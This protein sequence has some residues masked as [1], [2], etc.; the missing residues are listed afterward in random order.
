MPLPW[1]RRA[2][3]I[4]IVTRGPREQAEPFL[5]VLRRTY[6]PNKVL[7]V[8]S[9]G[10]NLKAQ[11]RVI[12]LLE[13]K[14]ARKGRPTAYVCEQGLCRLPTTDPAIFAGQLARTEGQSDALP[15][16]R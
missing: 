16:S 15:I 8:A 7:V 12:P 11:A 13:G 3:E 4:V 10:R 9:E 2:R 1:W 14:L 5:Q 6:L